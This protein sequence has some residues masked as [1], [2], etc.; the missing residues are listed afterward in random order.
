MPKKLTLFAI[1]WPIFIEMLLFM[2][3][4]NMD[5]FMLS[6]YSD[7]AVAAMGV[8]NQFIMMAIT[9]FGF[10]SVGAAVIVAQYLGAE[11]QRAARRV[12]GVSL[13]LSFSFGLVL[14][15]VFVFARG[16][17]LRTM[18][19][20]YLQVY[21]YA[22]LVLMLVGG[23]VFLQGLL[24]GANAILRSYGY[25]RDTLVVTASM[26]VFNIVG[27]Y[28][29]LFGPLGLPVLGVPGVA[30]VTA[31]S[32]LLAVGIAFFLL[33]RRVG[34]PFRG[35]TIRAFP[36]EYVKKI[37]RIG[38]PAAGENLSY[39]G[40]QT[41]LTAVVAGMGSAAL[42]TRI[43]GRALNVFMFVLTISIAQGGQILI[44]RLMGAR[45]YDEIYRKCLKILRIALLSSMLV[46]VLFNIFS[47]QLF[48]LFTDNPEVIRMGRQVLIVFI[49]LEIGRALNMVVIGSLRATGD[50][51]F[52][53]FVGVFTMWG[54]GALGG[55]VFGVVLN[56]GVVGIV[57]GTA[58]DECVR[59][60]IMLY[61]WRSGAWRKKGVT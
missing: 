25:T 53:V 24:A 50:V 38:I 26:N 36:L 58:L 39:I 16:L 20:L 1:T 57:M 45:E 15:L 29:V 46:A 48:G 54:L 37:L 27:N 28:I 35:I 30:A 10:V 51:R 7:D 23:F 2:L 6:R 19:E 12:A 11:N 52:P 60:G 59:G 22:S 9:I 56:L 49:F 47:A 3:M 44:G 18:P 17:I 55:Y 41:F 8:A 31:I 40:Y 5:I 61:R 34:N 13:Y 14:S 32:R 21:E 43:Y 4:G 42:A 33:Y